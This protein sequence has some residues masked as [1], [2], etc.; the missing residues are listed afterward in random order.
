MPELRPTPSKDGVT[1]GSQSLAAF[2][3]PCPTCLA[4]PKA[5]QPKNPVRRPI[6][7]PVETK[8]TLLHTLLVVTALPW[9]VRPPRGWVI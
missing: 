8:G 4:S 3:S 2:R 5:R 6:E 1:I 9:V 7:A